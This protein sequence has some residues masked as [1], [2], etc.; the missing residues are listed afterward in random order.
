MPDV[1][2]FDTLYVPN[3]IMDT[4]STDLQQLVERYNKIEK[5]PE[6]KNL[7]WEDDYTVEENCGWAKIDSAEQLREHILAE[8]EHQ[9]FI[10]HDTTTPEELREIYKESNI[11]SDE[12]LSELKDLCV[13][14]TDEPTCRYNGETVT[15]L[16]RL[17]ARTRHFNNS[18]E[19]LEIFREV[20]KTS[21]IIILGIFLERKTSN[22]YGPHLPLKL[23][24][25]FSLRGITIKR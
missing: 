1:N 2:V 16:S 7:E 11:T 3:P 15:T 23:D 19:I 13:G 25:Q 12:F 22:M 5:I 21:D 6:N 10:W 18:D 9:I 4:Q 14:Y 20:S 17:V 24:Y 8:A